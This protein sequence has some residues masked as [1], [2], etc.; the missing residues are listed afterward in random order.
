[1]NEEYF[2]KTFVKK[3][4]QERLLHELKSEK[5]RYRGLDR[6][7]H[8][9][10]ELL[11]HRLVI[12]HDRNLENMPAFHDYLNARKE[13]CVLM[14]TDPWLDQKILPAFE[15]TQEAA[16][17]SEAVIIPGNGFC[18]VFGEAEKGGREKYLLEVKK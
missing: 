2:V 17:S 11:D 1:M 10:D 15:A 4:H 7:S 3:S 14:S 18:I 13:T 12:M 9:A 16:F 8:H 5:K 6:F